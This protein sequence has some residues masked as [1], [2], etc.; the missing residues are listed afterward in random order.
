MVEI[1]QLGA[2]TLKKYTKITSNDYNAGSFKIDTNHKC[3]VPV[4]T[5]RR[6][7]QNHNK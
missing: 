5:R 1:S 6:F 4:Q 7:S 2:W 3:G